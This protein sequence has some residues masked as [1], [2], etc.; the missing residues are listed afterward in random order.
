M[1]C[2]FAENK[3][4]LMELVA[5]AETKLSQFEHE[6]AIALLQQALS[7]A[8]DNTDAMDLLGEAF[9]DADNEEMK[10]Q[11]IKICGRAVSRL[12]VVCARV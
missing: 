4:S 6:E 9:M 7:I 5:E 11:A 8:P 3:K 10:M 2:N 1:L 12:T